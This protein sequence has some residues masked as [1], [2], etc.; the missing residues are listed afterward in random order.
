VSNVDGHEL[1]ACLKRLQPR[2]T[3]FLIASKT[4]TTVE[5]MTN[6]ALGAALVRGRRRRW[7]R[8]RAPFHRH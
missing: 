7:A 8:H 4:F 2:S 3:V 6:A 5:T 1:A